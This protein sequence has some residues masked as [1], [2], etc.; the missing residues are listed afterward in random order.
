MDITLIW[1]LIGSAL[2][3]SELFLPT[4]FL[5]FTMG[6][7]ALLVAVISVIFPQVPF[8]ATVALWLVFSI[9]LVLFVRKRF[10][11]RRRQS[12][13]GD[14]QEAETISE[15][16]P[17]KG[18]RVRYEGNS[19]QAICADQSCA[20]A[21]NEKVFVVRREGNILVVLPQQLLE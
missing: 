18:G 19:W 11:P 15:I 5:D 16:L 12:S 3:L 10:T 14:S 21:P 6:V 7:G 8:T 17:G 1:L 9:I 13:L 4:A 20:I 2:C